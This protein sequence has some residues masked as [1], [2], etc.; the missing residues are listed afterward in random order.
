M[1]L[2]QS[3]H[4][5]KLNVAFSWILCKQNLR[6]LAWSCPLSSVKKACW[7]GWHWPFFK[8]MGKW[9]NNCFVLFW[10]WVKW[11]PSFTCYIWNFVQS[12]YTA[13]S[14]WG[15]QWSGV[16][17]CPGTAD[18]DI[19]LANHQLCPGTADEDVLLANH[20]L[21]PGTANKDILLANHQLCPGTADEDILLANHQ[22]W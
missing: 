9:K 19:L 2:F 17:L 8:I 18:E 6:N 5:K 7:F 10:L 15:K 14:K 13:R 22:L 11:A 12:I 4:G 1:R 16:K 3:L 21:C 20:Q